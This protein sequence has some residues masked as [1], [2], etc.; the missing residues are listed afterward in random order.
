MQGFIEKVSTVC[1]SPF[2]H[3]CV[4]IIFG[5]SWIHQNRLKNISI[6]YKLLKKS[7][8]LFFSWLL[9]KNMLY[10]VNQMSYYWKAQG[11]SFPTIRHSLKS[12]TFE[13]R[14][15]TVNVV[16]S[17]IKCDSCAESRSSCLV[18][19]HWLCTEW[20]PRMMMGN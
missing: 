3:R 18:L 10:S 9:F 16:R 2:P 8:E 15:G 17:L 14:Y 11:F 19:P 13:R 1:E 7:L 20:K 4:T 6:I 5:T 12:V